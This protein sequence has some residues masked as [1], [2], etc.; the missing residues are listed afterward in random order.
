MA[1]AGDLEKVKSLKVQLLTGGCVILALAAGGAVASAQSD[2][3]GDG[4]TGSSAGPVTLRVGHPPRPSERVR[5][6]QRRLHRLA[7]RPGPIDGL[8]G[9]RTERAVRRFQRAEG[10]KVDGIVGPVSLAALRTQSAREAP[11]LP[12][13]QVRAPAR[14]PP[15]QA[16]GRPLPLDSAASVL[17][18]VIVMFAVVA[19]ATIAALATTRRGRRA[20]RAPVQAPAPSAGR[21]AVTAVGPTPE[22]FHE[23][24]SSSDTRPECARI[25]DLLRAMG[26]L[27]DEDLAAALQEQARSGGRIGEILVAYEVVPEAT[28]TTALACQLGVATVGPEDEPV[29]QL[30]ASEA[31]AWRAVALDGEAGADGAVA[32]ALADLAPER[33][34]QLEARLGRPIEARLCEERTLDAL[35]GRL[36]ADVDA[37]EV[38]HA[39]REE[40]PELSASKTS[41]SRP[42]AIAACGL[43]GA[44]AIGLVASAGL[45]AAVL[46]TVATA[47]FL[48]STGFRLYAA[49]QGSRGGATIDPPAEELTAMDERALPVYTILLPLYKEKPSTVGAL[50][51]ALSQLDYPKQK[52]DGVLLL[53][54]DDAQTRGAI[55][56]VGRP[57]WMRVLALPPG[58]PRTKPRA[59]SI[60]LRYAR[61]SVV[62]VYDA[63]DKPDPLQLKKAVWAFQHADDSLA[64]L[65]AKLGY[66]NPRQNLLTRWFTLEYDA[67]FN[68][69]LPGLHRMGAPIPLGGTSNHFR[70]PALEACLGWDPYNVTEDAD[71]GLRFSRLGFT[72]AMLESTTGEEA[73]SRVPNW[74]R[75]RSRWSKGYMQTVLVHTRRPLALL[76]ELGPKA[77]GAFLLTLGGAVGTALLAPI[78]WLLLALWVFVQPDWVAALFPGPVY[79][80]ASVSLVLGNFLLVFLSLC[81][82]VARGHDDLAP[83]A[84]LAPLYWGLISIAAYMALV[85]LF[86]RPS[87]WHKTEHGL[88]LA[89]EPA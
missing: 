88:H 35:L 36:Y 84:L 33:L 49:W 82:A 22:A 12:Q 78:F 56:E 61:G 83:H 4:P 6:V 63:E 69:F 37:D 60:G 41:L 18:V 55:E 48:A 66:Y 20:R 1:T 24:T 79:Y 77:T 34:A 38:I 73:N 7:Y 8:F 71:L 74:L 62:T 68:I 46:A 30:S 44:V 87:H 75:Q 2:R 27:T 16:P 32:V 42:Q 5:E 64:C 65:Q 13:A 15:S 25:G 14:R 76:R 17:S 40:S 81:A 21:T 26:A 89:E 57:A 43:G 50:F 58:T 70:R 31:R 10:L 85:E 47:F 29:A 3:A 51:D 23:A 54:S 80:A 72:T 11:R 28:V 19:L 45:V 39:L 9:P 53:E 86:V 52:L 59:M 67:W